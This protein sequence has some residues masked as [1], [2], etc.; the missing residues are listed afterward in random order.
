MKV[1]SFRNLRVV[2]LLICLAIALVYTQ[3]QK[4]NSTSWFKPLAVIIFPINV[5]GSSETTKYIDALNK[6][7]FQEIEQFF[8]EASR[9]YNLIAQPPISVSV[10]NRLNEQPPRPPRKAGQLAAIWW[11][12]KL[13]FWAYQHT[14]DN[15]SNTNRIRLFVLYQ[16]P[17]PNQALPHSLGLQKGLIGIVHAYA[18]QQQSSQNAVV[19]TH[20][21]LHTVG[22]ED[23]YDAFNQPVYPVGYAEPELSPLH[24]QRFAEIMAGRV[25]ISTDTAKMPASLKST[26]VGE[27][28]AK[29][30][31]WIK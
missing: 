22:A 13:R 29:E 12:L 10:G 7:S 4:R 19:I 15:I 20:E 5:D 26:V 14:P 11:S 17:Q 21:L 23:K 25:A 16:Q 1:F 9:Q 27:Q 6:D 8:A 24:P 31:N 2:I 28:T 30:I 3:E 18:N